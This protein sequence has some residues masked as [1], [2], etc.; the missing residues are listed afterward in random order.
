M[1]HN[2]NQALAWLHTWSGLLVGWLLFVIF[3]GGTIACFDKELDYWM[4]P[5]LHGRAMPRTPAFGAAVDSVKLTAP[6]A[7]SWYLAAGNERNPALQAYTFMDDGTETRTALDPVSGTPLVPTAGGDFFFELHYNLHAGNLGLMIVALAGMFALAAI[8]A[9]VLIHKRIFKDFFTF[10]PT[11]GGQRAWLDAHNLTGVLGLPFHLLISYTGVAIFATSYMFAGVNAGYGGDIEKLFHEAGDFYERPE[12][13]KPLPRMFTVDALVDDAQQRLGQPVAWASIH[14]PDDTS[15]TIAFGGDHTRAIAWNFHTVTYDAADGRFLHI[16]KPPTAGYKTYEWLGGLHMAQFGGA[17]VRWLYFLLGLAGCVM[18]AAGMQVWIRKRI[19]RVREAGAVSGYGLVRALN[20]G[21]VAGFPFATAAMLLANRML[22]WG[23]AER[24]AA[25][26]WIF[27]GAWIVATMWGAWADRR[28][29]GWR[30]LFAASG[31][32]FALVPFAN[33]IATPGSALWATLH[34]EPAL[35]AVD[36]TALAFAGCFAW[37]ATR[38]SRKRVAQV[39]E[40]LA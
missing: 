29:R 39:E 21:V 3:A 23:M 5:Q 14:H 30:D 4:Q 10:R 1:K 26:I 17:S 27:C 19:K 20:V 6:D 7:H 37:M 38:A 34:R 18:I 32:A 36:L 28:D 8:V 33:A 35:A 25:E 40:A 11:A 24:D 22:P 16:T 12:V 15:A 2:T 31:V 9:G 13:G